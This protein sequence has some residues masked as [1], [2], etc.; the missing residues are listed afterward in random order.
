[1]LDL[2]KDGIELL[3]ADCKNGKAYVG[4]RVQQSRLYSRTDKW[5]I[6]LAIAGNE[7]G[8]R[9]SRWLDYWTGKG[10]DAQQMM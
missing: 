1:M 2:D 5:K 8:S 7:D 6:M 4:K 9:V 10:T 3:T